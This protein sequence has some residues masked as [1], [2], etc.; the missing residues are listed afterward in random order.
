MARRYQAKNLVWVMGSHQLHGLGHIAIVRNDH[1]TIIVIQSRIIEQVNGQINVRAF[2][3]RLDNLNRI[4]WR[5]GVGHANIMLKKM[6]VMNRYFGDIRFQSAN[7]G[8]LL[9]RCGRIPRR[10]LNL[11]REIVNPHN[12]ILRP[13]HVG[14]QGF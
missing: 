10:G 14:K 8:L 11:C 3:Y 2:F 13:Q 4:R 9:L 5:V 12:L 1:G 7:I 6:A